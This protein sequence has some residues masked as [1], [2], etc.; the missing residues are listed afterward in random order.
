MLLDGVKAEFP[1]GW[2]LMRASVTEPAFTLRFEG[3]SKADMLAVARR[4]LDGVGEVGDAIWE[5]VMRHS[6]STP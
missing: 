1:E 6:D 3:N 2:A 5:E 4:F